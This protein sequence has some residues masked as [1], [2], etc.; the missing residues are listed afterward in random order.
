MARAALSK[1]GSLLIW[2]DLQPQWLAAPTGKR[3]R[4]PVF[5][6]AAILA[7]LTLKALFGLPLRQTTGMVSSL[8]NL[9]GFAWPVPDFSTLRRRPDLITATVPDRGHVPFL[10][11]PESLAALRSFLKALP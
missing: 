1:R 4:Q 10:D 3:G 11:E 9:A 5:T 2:F 6:D 7:C 8:L